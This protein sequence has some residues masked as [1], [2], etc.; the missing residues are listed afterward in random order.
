MEWF[1]FIILALT[2]IGFSYWAFKDAHRRGY[3]KGWDDGVQ[4]YRNFRS[5]RR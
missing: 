4:A 3:D 2:V 1:L 5:I